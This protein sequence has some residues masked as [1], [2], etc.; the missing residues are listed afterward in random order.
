MFIVFQHCRSQN[1]TYAIYLH[2]APRAFSPHAL[3]WICGHVNDCQKCGSLRKHRCCRQNVCLQNLPYSTRGCPVPLCSSSSSFSSLCTAEVNNLWC[4]ISRPCISDIIG[5]HKKGNNKKTCFTCY[6]TSNLQSDT[7]DF[8]L[9]YF[10]FLS[11][12]F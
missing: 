12:F 1:S 8:C 2:V 4:G 3:T 9:N 10:A 7:V 6:T 11:T 5:T